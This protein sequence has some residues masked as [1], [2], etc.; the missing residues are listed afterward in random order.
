MKRLQDTLC[1]LRTKNLIDKNLKLLCEKNELVDDEILPTP[2][3]GSPNMP[4]KDTIKF[5]MLFLMVLRKII[6]DK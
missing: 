4:T 1:I 6:C 2:V 3:P 5:L